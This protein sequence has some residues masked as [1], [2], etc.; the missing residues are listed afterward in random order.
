MERK[1]RVL[2]EGEGG[3]GSLSQ[4]GLIV[5]VF[6]VKQEARSSVS[7]SWGEGERYRESE[8]KDTGW[9]GL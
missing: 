3:R 1:A 2:A 9:D 6:L 7:K 5:S 8:G 4:L